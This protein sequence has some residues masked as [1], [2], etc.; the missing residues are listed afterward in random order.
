M[1]DM[2][3]HYRQLVGIAKGW[4]IKSIAGW[5]D[6]CHRDL[7]ARH[8]ATVSNGHVSAST[9]TQKQLQSVL[10]D[11]ARRGWPRRRGF[12]CAEIRVTP[13][14]RMIVSLWGTLGQAGKVD[15]ATRPAMLA[16]CSRMIGEPVKN[17]DDMTNKQRSYIIECLKNWLE[18]S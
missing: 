13:Q 4:A 17:L 8:G 18:R 14:V 2:T 5:S 11:Y 10:D 7:L 15:R 3:K 16:Y 1:A 9:L 12:G 6:E